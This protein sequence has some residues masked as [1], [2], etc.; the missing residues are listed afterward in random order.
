MGKPFKLSIVSDVRD[1]LRGTTDVEDAVDKVADSLDQLSDAG[2]DLG[3]DVPKSVDKM[4][5]SLTDAGKDVDKLE[6]KFSDAV[7]TMK[8][9][10]KDAGKSI[11]DDVKKGTDDASEG[12]EEFK[13]EAQSSARE[14]AA[15]FSGEFDDVGDLIQEIA[16]NAFQGFGP[17]GAAAGMVAAAG[18]G[19]IVSQLQSAAEQAAAAKDQVI[20]LAGEISDV[21]GNP[22][23]LDWAE[24]LRDTLN[25][26]TD[27]KSWF[28]FW[29]DEPKT[30][31]E[32]WSKAA[33]DY[34]LDMKD[35]VRAVTGDAPSLARVYD[36]IDQKIAE[37]AERTQTYVTANGDVVQSV[38][39]AVKALGDLRSQLGDQAAAVQQAA[40]YQDLLA[41]SLS[42]LND[43]MAETSQTT[44]DYEDQVVSSLTEAG[45]SWEDYATDGVVNLDEYNAAIE[46]HAQAVRDFETNLVTASSSLSAEALNYVRSLGPEAAPLL[47][48]F[49]DAPLDQKRRTADNWDALGRA[50]T[51]GYAQS[52][53]LDKVTTDAA[54]KAQRQA[55]ANP[56]NFTTRLT[57]DLQEQVNWAAAN[58]RVPPIVF[59]G[60]VKPII[61]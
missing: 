45:A 8:R 14:A 19:I 12:A 37:A 56:I 26:I 7:D 10:A 4:G 40:S 5:D 13:D 31:L 41:D 29:Q 51:D 57:S 53:T 21:G 15:S 39:P 36:Q 30:R 16:A 33:T 61:D 47:Q 11:G 59:A 6:R 52:L 23:A 18:I 42:G 34:G 3:K 44:Q 28:E 49:V 50:A 2:G 46:A 54:A 22:A 32:E 35:M 58:V 24:R 48:A 43:I 25:E 60:K 1:F 9:G 17:A 27:E 55:D 20:D 38:D